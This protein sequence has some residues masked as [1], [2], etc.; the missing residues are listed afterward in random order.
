MKLGGLSLLHNYADDNTFATSYSLLSIPKP[1]LE[2][3]KNPLK[4]P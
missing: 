3:T 2:K 4:S 1:R